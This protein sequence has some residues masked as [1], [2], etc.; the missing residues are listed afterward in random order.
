VFH[1]AN[2]K[3]PSRF[4]DLFSEKRWGERIKVVPHLEW[5]NAISGMK[6]S[7]RAPYILNES[8]RDGYKNGLPGESGRKATDSRLGRF[9]IPNPVDSVH[10]AI[11]F[12]EG[13]PAQTKELSAKDDMVTTGPT[14]GDMSTTAGPPTQSDGPPTQSDEF[15]ATALGLRIITSPSQPKIVTANEKRS[16]VPID[17]NPV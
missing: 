1:I 7:K 13:K 8:I 2:P 17:R 12:L 6:E 15:S 3:S 9:T 5:F 11:Q 10:L 16:T 4:S 14:K